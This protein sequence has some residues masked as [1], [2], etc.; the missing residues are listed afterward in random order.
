M[1]APVD[2]TQMCFYAT[3]VDAGRYALLVG[4]FATKEDAD[5]YGYGDKHNAVMDA[6]C[7]ADSWAAFYGFGVTKLATGQRDGKLNKQVGYTPVEG[8]A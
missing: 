5:V 1:S 6:A 2:R 4:P 8:T 3:A 7:S